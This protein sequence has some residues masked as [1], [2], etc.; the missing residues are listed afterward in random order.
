MA[1]SI[2]PINVVA[3]EWTNVYSQ[4]TIAVGTAISVQHEAGSPVHVSISAAEPTTTRAALIKSG[5]W[6]SLS[7][8]E[9]GLW[10]YGYGRG[11]TIN[12][13]ED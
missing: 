13:Q 6:F 7:A 5:D 4:A 11:A 10:M 8:G 3:G 2:D 12:I 1:D 9:A